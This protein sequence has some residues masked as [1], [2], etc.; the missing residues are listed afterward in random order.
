MKNL[1][2]ISAKYVGAQY[3][4]GADSKKNGFD[5]GTFLYGIAKDLGFELPAEGD[6]I[7]MDNYLTLWE[8][9]HELAKELT[10]R[11]ILQ[12]GEEIPPSRAFVGDILFICE[13]KS[14][15]TFFGMYSGNATFI[16]VFARSGVAVAKIG[17]YEIRRAFRLCQAQ[18]R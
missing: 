5:C 3:K 10:I 2:E 1:A 4:K 7:H 6:P 8:Q 15:D 12:H 11:Y 16:A 18:K 13:P 14:G 17:D 9:D